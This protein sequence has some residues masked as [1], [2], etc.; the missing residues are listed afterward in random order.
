[1][2][3]K[4]R[5]IRLV[6]L[7]GAGMALAACSQE[8]LPK[9][10]KFFSGTSECAAEFG[11]TECSEAKAASE[12]VHAAEAPKFARKEE[13]EAQF[14]AENCETKQASNGSSI[15]MPMM[16]GYMMGSMMSGNR[17]SQPV[18]RGPGNSA[19]MPSGNKLLNVGNFSRSGS[20][21]ASAFQPARQVTQVS[22]GGFGDTAARN[23]SSSG[24]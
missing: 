12:K 14:G 2:M 22:R 3:K 9:E 8:D 7:G 16:M 15:F 19:V 6:L 24:G 5:S 1:M 10:S 23:H 11:A 18:Y 17:F 21:G 13:C 20:V 4:S